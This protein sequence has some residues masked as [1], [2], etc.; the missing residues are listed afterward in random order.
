MG[1]RSAGAA[2]A[3]LTAVGALLLTGLPVAFAAEPSTPMTAAPAPAPG[4]DKPSAALLSALQRDLHLTPRQARERLS[5]EAE[6]GARA[7]HLQIALGNNFAGAWVRG[8]ESEVLTVATTDAADAPA[9]ES[10][11]A[12]AQVTQYSLGELRLAAAKLDQA[13]AGTKGLDT[14]V[15]YVDIRRNRVAVQAARSSAAEALIAAAGVD[16]AIVD[17][18]LSPERPR[19]LYDIVGGDAFHVEAGRCSVGFSV[20]KGDEQGFATAGH[21]GKPGT[22][23]TG[24]NEVAQGTFQASTFPGQDT[25]WVKTGKDWTATPQVKGEGG[26]NVQVAGSTQALVG[27]A[28]CRSGSTSGWHCGEVEQHDT[29][30]T[31]QEGTVD[32]VTRT[33]VCA[34]PGDSGGPYISGS[35]AQGVTSGGSGDCTGGGT[36]FFQ[37]VNPLLEKYGLVLMTAAAESSATPGAETDQGS[38]SPGHVYRVGDEVTYDGVTYH[39]VQS[40]QAQQAGQPAAAPALWER[41]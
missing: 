35:Q 15:R 32:G 18:N 27:A 33:T 38:W 6:A 39:C 23:T 29:S 34:E 36:T 7:G 12:E 11:G 24:F 25:A 19:A 9:I 31:Y 5:N 22:A 10:A 1:H 3:A 37:P 40:H 8:G 4:A 41:A 20:T 21:C 16:R 14:P 13:A 2:H 26:E 17:I 28:V 30:V